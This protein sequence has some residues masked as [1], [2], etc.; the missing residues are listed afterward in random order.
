MWQLKAI[1]TKSTKIS[2]GSTIEIIELLRV[3]ASLAVTWFHFTNGN[4]AFLPPGILKLSGVYGWLGVEIFFVISGFIIPYS[5]WRGHFRLQSDWLTF[6]K[7]RVVRIYPAYLL[8]IAL[9]VFL[10]HLSSLTPGFGGEIPKFLAGDL[11]S[12]LFF[13]NGLLGKEWLNPVFWTLAIEFQY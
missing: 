9:I 7:K 12:H 4:A 8:T 13:L 1:E 10:W 5:M 6:F 2:R 11:I 3:T